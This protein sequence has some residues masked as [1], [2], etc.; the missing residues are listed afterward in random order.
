[1]YG[2]V[3]VW[4][5]GRETAEAKGYDAMVMS[6]MTRPAPVLEP[7]TGEKTQHAPRWRVIIHNDDVTPMDF[8]VRV[9]IDIF[10]LGLPRAVKVMLEAHVSGAAHVVTEPREAAEFHV[11]QAHSLARGRKVPLTFSMEPEE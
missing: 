4:K 9:L 5:W 1:M 11:E 7:A 8:V 10:R 2:R 3:E 6:G